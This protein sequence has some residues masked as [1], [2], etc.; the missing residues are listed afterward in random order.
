MISKEGEKTEHYHIIK[1]INK[2]LVTMGTEI[3]DKKSLGVFHTVTAP[4]HKTKLF[5]GFGSVEKIE[6]DPVTVG[7]FEDGYAVLANRS[8]EN[9]ASVKLICKA[10][11]ALEVLDAVSGEWM[12]LGAEDGCY[13]ITLD[14]GDGIMVKIA[15]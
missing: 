12:A 1:E 14:A 11:C 5:Q 6:G 15:E 9:E 2:E 13:N 3:M 10:G 7:F 4:E 8:Y